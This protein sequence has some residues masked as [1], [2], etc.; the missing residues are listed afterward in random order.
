MVSGILELDKVGS[1]R[2]CR[3]MVVALFHVTVSNFPKTPC[4]SENAARLYKPW[5][6]Y[7]PGK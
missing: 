6:F 4:F 2:F 3:L 7:G 5:V 1:I